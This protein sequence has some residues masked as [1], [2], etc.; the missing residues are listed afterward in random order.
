MEDTKELNQKYLDQH[1][2]NVPEQCQ[3]GNKKLTLSKNNKVKNL[4]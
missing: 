4:G 3:C 1:Y 2:I